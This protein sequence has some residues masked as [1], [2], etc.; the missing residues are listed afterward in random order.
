[1]LSLSLLLTIQY[2]LHGEAAESQGAPNLELKSHEGPY[3]DIVSADHR[4][5]SYTSDLTSYIAE[6][7]E[8]LFAEVPDSF[9]QKILISLRPEGFI[10]F[11]TAYVIQ[12]RSGGFV[13]LDVAWTD[14]LELETYIRALSHAYLIRYAMYLENGRSVGQLPEW[15]LSALTGEVYLSL[16]PAQMTTYLQDLQTRQ[17]KNVIEVL[18]EAAEFKEPDLGRWGYWLLSGLNEARP[19]GDLLARITQAALLGRD[20]KRNLNEYIQPLN[21]NLPPI[22][23]W[24]W[25]LTFIEAHREADVELFESLDSSMLALFELSAFSMEQGGQSQ[26]LLL[27]ELW[28]VREQPEVRK[29]IEARLQLLRLRLALVNPA[30]HNSIVTLGT[31]FEVLLE[32]EQES[33]YREALREFMNEFEGAKRLHVD[34]IDAITR[35]AF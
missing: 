24:G 11:E 21:F 10:P 2:V 1:M 8:R 31:L 19:K 18:A 12:T 5:I 25:W 22:D 33:E 16:R 15:L 9:P 35:S 34:T 4:S 30:Y 28:P 6:I 23:L 17:S 26:T 27:E 29:T 14:E 32:S 20:V 13:N 3:F 7:S